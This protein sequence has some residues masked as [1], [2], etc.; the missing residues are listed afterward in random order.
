MINLKFLKSQ[1][2]IKVNKMINKK[3]IKIFS[4][5]EKIG[6]EM[7]VMSKDDKNVVT[8]NKEATIVW[9]LLSKYDTFEALS[10]KF[11]DSFSVKPSFNSV[12]KDL[13][14]ILIDIYNAGLIYFEEFNE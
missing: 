3:I 1:L 11:Y 14:K 6:D 7:V 5:E 4:E 13:D 12:K 10:K 9:E 2:E 8:F